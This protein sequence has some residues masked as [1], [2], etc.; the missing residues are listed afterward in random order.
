MKMTTAAVGTTLM[1]NPMLQA[2]PRTSV[3]DILV[4][5]G[6]CLGLLYEIFCQDF[7]LSNS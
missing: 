3:T 5:F 7:V 6:F 1:V 4:C 2:I